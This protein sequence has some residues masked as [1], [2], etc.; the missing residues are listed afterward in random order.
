MSGGQFGGGDIDDDE[1]IDALTEFLYRALNGESS[2]VAG[3]RH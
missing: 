2:S 1:A 3:T